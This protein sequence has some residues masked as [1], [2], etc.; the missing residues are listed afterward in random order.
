MNKHVL[1]VGIGLMMGIG[2]L[3]LWLTAHDIET[4]VIGLRQI[5]LVL[6]VLGALEVVIS[7]VALVSP[8]TRH[9]NYDL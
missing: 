3:I 1:S 6:A 9:Q 5:G 4:P 2:G 8:T 7:G